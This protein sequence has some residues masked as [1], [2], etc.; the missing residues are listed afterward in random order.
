MTATESAPMSGEEAFTRSAGKQ[1]G[2]YAVYAVAGLAFLIYLLATVTGGSSAGGGVNVERNSI[3]I[4]LRQEPPQMDSTRA[5]DASSFS[6]LAHV[7]EGLLAY[8]ENNQLIPGIAE[9]WEVREDG[10]TFW[11]REEAKWSDGRPVTA[12]DF[13]FSWR[14]VVDPATAAEYSFILYS[15]KNARAINQGELAK[16]LLGVQAVDEHT[17]EVQFERP[18]PYFDK[19]AAFVTF[20]PIR[21][22]FFVSTNGRYGADTDTMLYNGPYVLADWVHGSTMLWQKNPYYWNEKKGLLDEI[23]TAYI[24]TDVNAKLNLFKDGQI[25]DT[26]LVAPMLPQAM[27]QRWN[28]DRAMDGSVFFLEFNHREGRITDNL[29]F[30][31]AI[32]LAQDPN[33]LVYKVL[34]EAAYL[35]AQSLF[36]VWIQGVDAA[37]RK[38][39]PPVEHRMNIARARDHLELAR[40]ELGLEEFPP[41]IFLTGDSPV[42]NLAGE[43]YQQLY[44]KNLGLEIRIDV[45]IFK[46][47]L[48]KMTS[49]DFDIVM[50][51]WGP[52]YF[53]AL[54]FGDLFASW[55]LNNRGRYNSAEMDRLV[56]IAQSE[57]DP[58]L[59]MDAM[60]E[61]QRI[62]YEDV[63]IVPMYER[64]W[65][66]VVD[67]RLK[68]L[69]RRSVG[70]EVD[71]NYAYIDVSDTPL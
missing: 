35:P 23:V 27:E 67:P 8:D 26:D 52:D 42:A 62:A 63:V 57:L 1:L 11:I 47:R 51:G 58:R 59:R 70:P 41:I 9:R 55:N 44:K 30:R 61:I 71:Y 29:N 46:Q 69:I 66:F 21:E 20:N 34:K 25:A 48:A 22:D 56:N 4:T 60:G 17:L 53:D 12:A 37:F 36:P 33:E 31:K 28:I 32:L 18:T 2:L 50:A 15:I 5:T 3:T 65:S 64:G 39:Y 7:M 43:Y 40:Q 38:E 14:R 49:G 16:E 19:L 13:V 68:G 10:A 24:T 54:T 45:Q 6:V